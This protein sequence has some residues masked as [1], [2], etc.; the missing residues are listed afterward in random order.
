LPGI[1]LVGIALVGII[2]VGI[3]LVG[4]A[5]I[6]V[7]RVAELVAVLVHVVVGA[8]ALILRVLDRHLRLRGGDDAIVMLGMLQIVLGHDPVARTVCVAGELRVFFRDLL[9]RTANLHVRAV[10]LIVAGQGVG[11][12][13]VLVLIRIVAAAAATAAHAPVLLLWP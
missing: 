2:L 3:A 12:L 7:V 6:G 8:V 1:A 9:C 4:I 11:A 5:L 13:A 10:A